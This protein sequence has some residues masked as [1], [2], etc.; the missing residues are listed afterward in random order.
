MDVDVVLLYIDKISPDPSNLKKNSRYGE[1]IE[2]GNEMIYDAM[3][4]EIEEMRPSSPQFKLFN[5]EYVSRCPCCGE[6]VVLPSTAS[7]FGR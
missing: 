5:E 4:L 3:P 2:G 7:R 6:G 1:A